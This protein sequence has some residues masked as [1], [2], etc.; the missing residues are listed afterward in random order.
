MRTIASHALFLALALTELAAA[1]LADVRPPV[2]ITLPSEVAQAASG[3]EYAGALDVSVGLPGLLSDF[4]LIGDGWQILSADFP[5]RAAE[6]LAGT[7]RVSYRAIPAN[8]DAPLTL[9]FRHDGRRA[10]RSFEVGPRGFARRA[11]PHT[12]QSVGERPALPQT[13]TPAGAGGEPPAAA[14]RGGAIPL[15]FFGRFVYQRIDGHYVGAD[16]IGV[17]VYDDDGAAGDSLVDEVIWSGLTDVNGYFDSGVIFWDDCDVVG[18]DDPDIYVHFECDTAIA[19]VQVS[20]IDETDYFWRTMDNIIADFTGSEVNF[21]TLAPGDPEHQGAVHIWNSIIRAHRY[22][23]E[24]SGISLPIVDV[25]WPES[26]NGAFYVSFYEEIHIG[27]NRTWEE[28]THVHEYGHHFL[29]NRADPESTD[30]CNGFCDGDADGCN[31]D[32]DCPDE[33]HCS[34]CPENDHDAWNEGWPDWLGDVIPRDYPNR[35]TFDGGAPY[36]AYDGKDYEAPRA[37][38][39]DELFYDPH[40]TEG[41]VAALLRD[42]EDS[43]QDDHDADGILDLLCLGP[44]EI[45]YV[46]DTAEPT[47]LTGF[48]DAFR[49]AYPQHTAQLW[50]TAFNVGGA[51]YAGPVSDSQP[52]GVVGYCDSPSHPIGTGGALPCITLEFGAAPDDASGASLYSLRVAPS[53]AGLLPDMTPETVS[54]AANCHLR[55]TIVV[56]DLGSY[57]VSIR[58]GDNAGN[59]SNEFATFGPFI[60][61]DCNGSG[62]LD[63]CDVRCCAEICDAGPPGICSLS[64]AICPEGSCG[65]SFDCNANFQPDECDIALGVSEDCDQDGIP[66]ECETARLKHWDGGGDTMHPDWF[67]SSANWVELLAPAI[68]D[69]VCIGPGQ[70]APLLRQTNPTLG[71]FAC[72]TDFNIFP[73]AGVTGVVLTLQKPAFIMGDLNM[74]DSPSLPLRVIVGD[75]LTIHGALN[76]SDGSLEGAVGSTTVL[77]GHFV[78]G[79]VGLVNHTLHLQCDTLVSGGWFTGNA[80]TIRNH[81]GYTYTQAEGIVHQGNGLV[82]HNDGTFIKPSGT[83]VTRLDS[84]VTNTGDIQLHEGTLRIGPGLLNTGAIVGQPGTTLEFAGSQNLVVGSSLVGDTIVFQSSAPPSSRHVR[85][86]YDAGAVTRIIAN[87]NVTWHSSATVV[88]YGERLELNA[89]I[90]HFEATTGAPLIF[91]TIDL[92]N[93]ATAFFDGGDPIVI[94]G[95]LDLGPT[96]TLRGASQE[97]TI[98]G[99]LNWA[100]AA[101]ISQPGVIHANGGIVLHPSSSTRNLDRVLNNA[102]TATMLGA[103]QIGSGGGVNNLGGGVWDI[104]VDGG[105]FIG[106][107]FTLN[108]A[109]LLVK[110][111]GAGNATIGTGNPGNRP[112][113]T[114]SGT[115]AAQSGTLTIAWGSYTQTAGETLLNGGNFAMSGSPA[116]PMQLNGGQLRG[117][118]TVT[119]VVNNAAAIVAPGLS[120]GALTISGAYDQGAGAA[121]AIE[122]GGTNP[123]EFDTVSVSGAA[124]LA[125]TLELTRINGFNPSAGSTFAIVTAGSL[126]GTFTTVSGPAASGFSVSYTPTQVILTATG[127]GLTGDLDG[128][129]DVDISDLAVL[130]SHYG[131]PSPSPADGDLDGD[132][133]VDIVDLAAMLSNYGRPCP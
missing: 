52:P 8:A 95:A 127:S 32:A 126:T 43:D 49:A 96:A 109:G 28:G 124:T 118:G 23:A 60:V 29:E 48:L 24:R 18:C 6:A 19:Q 106:S 68:G 123:T 42:I 36:T 72:H 53:A 100:A 67:H 130:L 21:G 83:G 3:V 92:E 87:A 47:T 73:A 113:I 89:G 40:I 86:A 80:A 88:D 55:S 107:A 34:W 128:D 99:P 102:A 46:V 120:A 54:G 4:E 9:R 119:A 22:I 7:Y 20:T 108:N 81:A 44:E 65:A 93:N 41:F 111:A 71:D 84:A 85:G 50:P 12:A 82:F 98:H 125:G 38:C 25:Q 77:G 69:D 62:A 59:W 45:F 105:Q 129:C 58:A 110:S 1:A 14:T 5:D 112:T 2:K 97:I 104:Q 76:W 114:N 122:I 115:I 103:L 116:M 74:G 78:N 101:H 30:Y 10:T 121:L 51:A 79:G 61:T 57:Y 94:N 56:T 17:W 90:G 64:G 15:R 39:V 91:E 133:D 37:C 75:S 131:T 63:V 117:A 35:Y 26:E 66:D 16:N 70:V 27:P 33:G 13:P 132:G 31:F 11:H